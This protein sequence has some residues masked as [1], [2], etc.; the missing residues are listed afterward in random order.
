MP[1]QDWKCVRGTGLQDACTH[2]QVSRVLLPKQAH[3]RRACGN[4]QTGL[5]LT[6]EAEVTANA[7]GSK[8]EAEGGRR[9]VHHQWTTCLRC[10]C[11]CPR[12]RPAAIPRTEDGGYCWKQTD[13]RENSSAALWPCNLWRVLNFSLEFLVCNQR[14]RVRITRINKQHLT[15]TWRGLGTVIPHQAQA[16]PENV[17]ICLHNHTTSGRSLWVSTTLSLTASQA[18]HTSGH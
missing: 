15:H 8:P 12:A 5:R 11:T 16:K 10:A 18:G 13:L 2:A 6:D 14:I 1:T 17:K 9:W 4:A 3:S 7:E